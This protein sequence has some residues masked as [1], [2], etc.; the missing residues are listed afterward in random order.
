LKLRAGNPELQWKDGFVI[1]DGEV[2]YPWCNILEF[3]H[4][5]VPRLYLVLNRGMGDDIRKAFGR[6]AS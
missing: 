2:P 5:L 4:D 1:V 6:D 3:R